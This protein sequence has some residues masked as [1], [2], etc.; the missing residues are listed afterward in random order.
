MELKNKTILITGGT[1]GIGYELV[2]LLH[3]SGNRIVVLGRSKA[4]LDDLAKKFPA[5]STYVCDLSQRHQIEKTMDAVIANHLEITVL[6]NNA[7]VQLTP[8]FI[9]KDF[10]FDGIGY[11]ITTNLTSPLWITSLL[12]AGTLL[13]QKE[14]L[15]VNISSGLA[16]FPKKQS[17]VY[18]ATKA[19]LHSISQS[20]RYQLERTPV[21][22]SEVLLPLVDTPMT[23]GR[24]TDKISAKT[25]A[26]DIL[27]GIENGRDEIY[28]GKT[29]W[30]PMMARVAPA[31]IKRVLKRH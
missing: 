26:M 17:A 15:I 13:R 12:L 16:F 10:D 30:L 22:V 20:L 25:A 29:R 28:I 4:K 3:E 6:I 19:A 23:H 14:A 7:A 24:G 11:E 1:S 2:G 8:T 31:L 18:C 21:R 5:V 9:S 27:A